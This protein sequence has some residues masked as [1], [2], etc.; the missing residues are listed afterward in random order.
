MGASKKRE[1]KYSAKIKLRLHVKSSVSYKHKEYLIGLPTSRGIRQPG[2][3]QGQEDTITDEGVRRSL[4]LRDVSK[5]RAPQNII[6]LERTTGD[7]GTE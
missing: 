7:F 4:A 3:P 2:Q 1:K 5:R 6:C